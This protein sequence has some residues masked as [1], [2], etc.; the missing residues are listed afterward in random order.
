MTAHLFK[1]SQTF[2][3]FLLYILNPELK[4]SGVLLHYKA[5]GHLHTSGCSSLLSTHT[6]PLSLLSFPFFCGVC[7]SHGSL[8]SLTSERSPHL[9]ISLP[10]LTTN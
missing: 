3:F 6:L 8:Y 10:S 4:D 5:V 7:D 1:A 9:L 2:I